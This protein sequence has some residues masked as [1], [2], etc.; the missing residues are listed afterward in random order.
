MPLLSRCS[1]KLKHVW[2]ASGNLCNWPKS[3][4]CYSIVAID[5]LSCSL[6]FR[7]SMVFHG[8]PMIS[9]CLIAKGIAIDV[10][11][12]RLRRVISVQILA[13]NVTRCSTKPDL[14]ACAVLPLGCAKSTFQKEPTQR[15]QSIHITVSFI[16]FLGTSWLKENGTILENILN[17]TCILYELFMIYCI[18]MDLI[19]EALGFLF[20]DSRWF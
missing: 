4:P 1:F 16:I 6:Q 19:L 5:F 8:F 18:N 3:H 14:A 13:Q 20:M 17:R 15:T 12:L 11:P 10:H 2:T 7:F 9:Q